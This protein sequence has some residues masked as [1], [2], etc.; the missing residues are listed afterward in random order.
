[1]LVS[2]ERKTWSRGKG[3]EATGR[4]QEVPLEQTRE[5]GE[6]PRGFGGGDIPGASPGKPLLHG[7]HSCTPGKPRDAF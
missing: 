7:N 3:A 5:G 4:T 1:M 2:G 6:E